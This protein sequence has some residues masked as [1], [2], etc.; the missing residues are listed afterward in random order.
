MSTKFV[1]SSEP[2]PG[3][4]FALR[5]MFCEMLF[6]WASKVAPDKYVPSYIEAAVAMYHRGVREQV[7]RTSKTTTGTHR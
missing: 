2:S 1:K 7:E 6:E 3:L 5:A 4:V